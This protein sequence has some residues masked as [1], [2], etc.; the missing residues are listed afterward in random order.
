MAE[1]LHGVLLAVSG[2]DADLLRAIDA[3]G[4]GLRVVRRCADTAELLSAAMAGLAALVVVDT[5]F[6]DLD[7]SVVDRLRHAG[8]SGVVLAPADQAE[9]WAVLG[10]PVEGRE[11]DPEAVRARVQALARAVEPAQAPRTPPQ[12]ASPASPAGPGADD[13]LWAE[14][15]AS[16]ALAPATPEGTGD[17]G[18]LSPP[19]QAPSAGSEGRPSA[20]AGE[21]SVRRGTGTAPGGSGGRIVVVWGPRGSSGRTTIAAAL[22][23]SLAPAGGTILVDADLE[24]PCLTQVLGLPEDSSG[25]A[26]AA[27]L[28]GHGR[29]DDEAFEALLTPVGPS[30][31]LLSGLGRPG[32]WRE[33]PPSAM[34]EVWARC[35]GLAA[36]TVLDVAGGPVDDSVDEYTLE[37]GRGAVVAGLVR[38]AD[39]VLVVGGA[40]PVG[41]RRLLQLLGDLD[42]DMRPTG[43]VE[44][45]VTRVRSRVAGPSPQRAVR[46]A[47]E[48]YGRVSE[49]SLVPDD[50]DTADRCLMEGRAVTEAAPDSVLGHA[51]TELADR[52]D[53]ETA[54]S[55]RE[56]RAGRR[57]RFGL[58]RRREE[59][60]VGR[61]RALRPVR[62]GPEQRPAAPA[63]STG[64]PA[65]APPPGSG[66]APQRGS[67]SSPG[68]APPPPPQAEAMGTGGGPAAPGGRER[69]RRS[70]RAR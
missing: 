42:G 54:A 52:V 26:T 62:R 65:P 35:R 43:R 36:W 50:P 66:A 8:V 38:S 49:A 2:D 46:D 51:L 16:G 56:G 45:V 57:R 25:L 20:A 30:E 17:P 41:I 24:G 13:R 6:D 37:P 33:L 61:R 21:A 67:R 44:V 31:R 3:R 23:H 22:A 64:A 10:W 63:P 14:L 28:A 5:D 39:V 19:G 68:A 60:A 70:R 4:S 7:P 55:R 32:R 29:L 48:R 1:R 12:A 47:L 53:P 15:T 9:H 59:R 40:D 18:A 34:S 58:R 11:A 27:R 69:R